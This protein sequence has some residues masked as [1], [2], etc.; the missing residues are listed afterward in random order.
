LTVCPFCQESLTQNKTPTTYDNAK[1]ALRFIADTYGAEALLTK[2]LFSDIAPTLNDERELIKIFRDKG[3]LEVLKGALNAPPSEQ[4]NTIKR[5]TAKLP[6]YLQNSPE[7]VSL[8]NYFAEVLGWNVSTAS[9]PS[10]K[11][12]KG[13]RERELKPPY[14]G[15][16]RINKMMGMLT[17]Q[18]VK[19]FQAL[20]SS[21]Y[22]HEDDTVDY[23]KGRKFDPTLLYPK[24]GDVIDFAFDD[25]RVLDVQNGQALLLSEKIIE[26]RA[27]HPSFVDITWEKCELR[28][29]LNGAFYNSLGQDKSRIAEQII[30]NPNNPWFNTSGGNTTSDKI[31]LLSLDEVCGLTGIT[32][33][34]DSSSNLKNKSTWGINDGNNSKRIA[35]DNS[36]TACH[37]WLRSSGSKKHNAARVYTD[38]RVFVCGGSVDNTSVGVRPAL[39]LNL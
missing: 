15:L 17:A 34:G 7:A 29:Y 3:A 9:E 11:K 21:W 31:F 16:A 25:W 30:D 28:S 1:D 6:V 39:W 38:G 36:G 24:I 27:Y 8:L 26:K 4:E 19:G 33:F 18:E 2:N 35:K 37:W 13:K 12:V 20:A 10:G 5:A 22:K 32:Y 14:R 23:G